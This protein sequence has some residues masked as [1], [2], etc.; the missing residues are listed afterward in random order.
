MVEKQLYNIET[1]FNSNNIADDTKRLIFFNA[2]NENKLR[3]DGSMD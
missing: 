3:K 1:L 2:E